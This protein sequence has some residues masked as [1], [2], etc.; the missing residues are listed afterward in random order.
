MDIKAKLDEGYIHCRAIVELL[1]KPK[2][3]VDKAI[4]M[5]VERMKQ[6]KEL[7]VLETNF[8]EPE[9]K[10]DMFTTFVEIEM[11]AK[12]S[13]KLVWFCFD[14]MPSSIEVIAPDHIHYNG[15]TFSNFL[16]DLQARLHDIDLRLKITIEQNKILKNNATN[17]MKNIMKLSLMEKEKDIDEIAKNVGITTEQLEPFLTEFIKQGFVEKKGDLYTWKT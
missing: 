3:Y 5:Y 9:A 2:D 1:G 17:L 14:Y 4:R 10:E 7:I 15:Q 11:L 12:S 16:N 8:N 6:D 13:E